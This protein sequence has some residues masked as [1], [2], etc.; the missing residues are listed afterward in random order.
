[1]SLPSSSACSPR[2]PRCHSPPEWPRRR[3]PARPSPENFSR[4]WAHLLL[5]FSV[6]LIRILWLRL[7][8]VNWT[9]IDQ[10]EEAT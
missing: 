7:E 8:R 2:V 9:G 1:L 4:R 10:W 3:P 5:P 6:H